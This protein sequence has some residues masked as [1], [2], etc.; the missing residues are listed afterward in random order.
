MGLPNITYIDRYI[1]EGKKETLSL[2]NFYDTLLVG[3][4]DNPEHIFKTT[5]GD[6][7]VNHKKE[8]D[9]IIQYYA[10][11]QSMFYK[12]K[13]V[14]YELYGTTELWFA[15][16]RLNEMRNITEFHSPIIKIYDSDSLK[17]LISIFFKREG[18]IS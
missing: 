9:G 3:D 2:K 14:S 6:F 18:I 13:S 16:L 15:L 5:I 10:V 12:P 11:P 7:F 8:L 4:I 1:S 17:E